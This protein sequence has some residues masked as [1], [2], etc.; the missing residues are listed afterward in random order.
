MFELGGKRIQLM[1]VRIIVSKLVT[2][3][4]PL[5]CFGTTTSCIPRDIVS[6]LC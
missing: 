6:I 3:I 5:I 1:V 2:C 4:F